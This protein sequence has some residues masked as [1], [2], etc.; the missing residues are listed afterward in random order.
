MLNTSWKTTICAV[1]SGLLLAIGACSSAD[2]SE[3][4][5][6][7]SQQQEAVSLSNDTDSDFE[8]AEEN[9]EGI[10]NALAATLA[11]VE[12]SEEPEENQSV[13]EVLDQAEQAAEESVVDTEGQPS[14]DQLA[15]EAMVAA[16][17]EAAVEESTMESV[18]SNV[19][20]TETFNDNSETFTYTV[21]EGDWL[22]SVSKHIYGD[23][24]MWREVAAENGLN[25]PNYIVPGQ[26]LLS[27]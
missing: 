27:K 19:A 20:S 6:A 23:A 10:D 15:D 16:T 1:A 22:S 3:E 11:A 9:N 24:E 14:E 21:R 5:L 2:Q 13:E 7:V 25:N 4:S 12:E 8:V 26:K 18:D 17:S